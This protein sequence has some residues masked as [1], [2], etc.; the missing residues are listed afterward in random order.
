ML[1]RNTIHTPARL[2]LY[3]TGAC[4]GYAPKAHCTAAPQRWVS[5]HFEED[6]LDRMRERLDANPQAMALRRESA[7]HPFANLK[8]RIL[9]NGRFL[10]R[11]LS[12]GGGE[13]ALSVLAYNFRRAFNLLGSMPMRQRLA[14]RLS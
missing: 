12:G 9:G 1:R 6:A 2:V 8:C 13:M 5:R 4:G 7:E 14:I 10:L 11:G 3:T